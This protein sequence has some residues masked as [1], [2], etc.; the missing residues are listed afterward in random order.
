MPERYTSEKRPYIQI[1]CQKICE[2]HVLNETRSHRIYQFHVIALYCV[3][4]SQSGTNVVA[5]ALWPKVETVRLTVGSEI[6]NGPA[7]TP[8]NFGILSNLKNL[9]G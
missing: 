2:K 7:R 8:I 3:G 1:K 5:L 9:D 6:W 4:Q